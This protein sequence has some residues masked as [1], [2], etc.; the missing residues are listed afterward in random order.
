MSLTPYVYPPIAGITMASGSFTQQPIYQDVLSYQAD[1]QKYADAIGAKLVNAAD[2]PAT[3]F[4]FKGIDANAAAQPWMVTWDGVSF[5]F[6]GIAIDQQVKATKAVT[7]V[8]ST[9]WDGDWGKEPSGVWDFTPKPLTPA[10][11]VTVG[12]NPANAAAWATIM[13]AGSLTEAQKDAL[14]VNI[15]VAVG[16]KVP[17]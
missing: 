14:L 13:G 12:P 2:T 9:D 11:P 3:N 15:A 5:Y 8:A 17:A 16:A 6:A 1:A 10:P 4:T 7:G